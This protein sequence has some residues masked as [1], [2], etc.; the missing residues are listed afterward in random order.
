MVVE[1]L[2]VCIPGALFNSL[3]DIDKC[4]KLCKCLWTMSILVRYTCLNGCTTPQ[5]S[6]F[7]P[8]NFGMLYVA[9]KSDSGTVQ[10]WLTINPNGVSCHCPRKVCACT[11]RQ[12]VFSSPWLTA[13]K[14]SGSPLQTDL[15]L[16]QEGTA[17]GKDLLKSVDGCQ[18]S[19]LLREVL[20]H[21]IPS[22]HR[23]TMYDC[24]LQYFVPAA[25]QSSYF[26]K[27][28]LETWN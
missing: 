22:V 13:K 21:L 11:A 27:I 15:W 5:A 2:E 3:W 12:M 18:A 10:A 8:H 23:D 7:H 20:P 24:S 25:P 9:G 19:C 14:E 4:G 16:V 6:Q 28:Y 1:Q 17:L 26:E